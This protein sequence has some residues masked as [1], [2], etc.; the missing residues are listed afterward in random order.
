MTRHAYE[1]DGSRKPT[2]SLLPK[3]EAGWFTELLRTASPRCRRTA[4]ARPFR[5]TAWRRAE[6]A[7]Y[8]ND[9]STEFS[10]SNWLRPPYSA[11]AIIS[12]TATVAPA[13]LIVLVAQPGA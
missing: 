8:D 1:I 4:H 13:I 9:Q 3:P 12:R 6:D 7:G 2:P 10:A 5:Q 11:K